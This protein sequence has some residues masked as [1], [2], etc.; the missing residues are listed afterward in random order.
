MAIT[1][2]FRQQIGTSK[3]VKSSGGDATITLASLANGSYRQSTKLDFGA[4]H[5]QVY[6]VYL[7]IELAATPT[8]GNVIEI[9]ANPS[10]SS[11]AATDNRGGCS[12]S[13]AA[14]T[15]Y[16]SN[17]AA[18]ALQ[19]QYVG[20]AVLTAQAT[21]TVQKIFVGTYAPAQRYVSFVLKNGAGSAVH[22]SDSNCVLTLTP[23]EPTSEAS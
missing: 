22:S 18:S 14:Y 15:G 1:A 11:T 9:F 20:A 10:S 19:L 2:A 8:A 7:D 4:T 23:I 3:T 6:A 13:D 21:S 5:A 16:S 17:A 12:G